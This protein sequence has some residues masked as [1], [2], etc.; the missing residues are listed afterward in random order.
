MVSN[1]QKLSPIK[2]FGD[3]NFQLYYVSN[4]IHSFILFQFQVVFRYLIKT[5]IQILQFQDYKHILNSSQSNIFHRTIQ[6]PIS[7]DHL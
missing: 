6:F 7:Y 3:L 2:K 1:I 4:V 5:S